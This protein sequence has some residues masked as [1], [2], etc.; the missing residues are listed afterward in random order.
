MPRQAF[1]EMTDGEFRMFAELLKGHCGLHFAA[2]SRF[3][4][5]QRVRRRMDEL[6]LPSYAAYHYELTADDA[7]L[8][9]GNLVDEV[10]T[11]ETY[12]FREHRQLT[13]LIDEI[14]PEAMAA[15]SGAAPQLLNDL[16]S[17]TLLSFSPS[18]C[19]TSILRDSKPVLMLCMRR[20]SLLLAISRR[21]RSSL[22]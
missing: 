10:T 2:E 7:Q 4:L 9:L 14:V 6:A 21:S 1:P 19:G 11:N 5:E 22:R 18:W 13:A 12:F 17:G 15:L 3:V 8:E 20:R 16:D